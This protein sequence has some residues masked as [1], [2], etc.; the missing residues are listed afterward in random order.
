MKFVMF[1]TD[2]HDFLTAEL[3]F[4]LCA[5]QKIKQ[6]KIRYTLLSHKEKLF[7]RRF[8]KERTPQHDIT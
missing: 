8:F 6:D 2:L 7:T 1:L 5:L 4:A 3:P